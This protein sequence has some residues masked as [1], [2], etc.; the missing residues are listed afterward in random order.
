MA[1]RLPK[2]LE[3]GAGPVEG[4]TDRDRRARGAAI[5]AGDVEA[6]GAARQR[7]KR[8]MSGWQN[9]SLCAG[10]TARRVH[11]TPHAEWFAQREGPSLEQRIFGDAAL[12][13]G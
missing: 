8:A 7:W 9:V 3:G 13:K 12:W 5:E 10:R 6:R 4:R 1:R 11:S 2:H